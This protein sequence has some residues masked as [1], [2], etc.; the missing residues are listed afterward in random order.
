M[1]VALVVRQ[2]SYSN[3]KCVCFSKQ[4]GARGL[5]GVYVTYWRAGRF[6]LILLVEGFETKVLISLLLLCDVR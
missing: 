3:W 6:V 1:D 5:F 4:K 2:M